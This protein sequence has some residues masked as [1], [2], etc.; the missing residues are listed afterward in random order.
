M[1]H[2][3]CWDQHLQNKG[4]DT[5][6]MIEL[7]WVVDRQHDC[8]SDCFSNFYSIAELGAVNLS[9]ELKSQIDKLSLKI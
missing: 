5:F 6:Q 2:L 4:L 3:S 7:Q 1:I 8:S 9:L